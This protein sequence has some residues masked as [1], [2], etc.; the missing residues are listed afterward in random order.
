MPKQ[1]QCSCSCGQKKYWKGRWSPG[2]KK[3]GERGEKKDVKKTFILPNF[4]TNFVKTYFVPLYA[5]PPCSVLLGGNRCVFF[6][7]GIK[8]RDL[9]HLCQDPRR[10]QRTPSRCRACWCRRMGGG[11]C[12]LRGKAGG[13]S[14]ACFKS[15]T[16]RRISTLLMLPPVERYPP[17]FVQPQ[18][19]FTSHQPRGTAFFGPM[20]FV[21][22]CFPCL[23][24]ARRPFPTA[25]PR[26]GGSALFW[27]PRG[28]LDRNNGIY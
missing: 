11:W 4:L 28:G 18:P 7:G 9:G 24:P 14:T 15:N 16:P 13:S 23:V 8:S 3:G 26:P 1:Q 17:L 27:H 2:S 19:M 20:I 21:V 22:L 10:G 5:P 25:D 12:T 6:R